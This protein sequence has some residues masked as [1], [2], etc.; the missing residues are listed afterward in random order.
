MSIPHTSL[1][2]SVLAVSNMF[3]LHTAGIVAFVQS[4]SKLFDVVKQ[5]VVALFYSRGI[6]GWLKR[7]IET[8]CLIVEWLHNIVLAEFVCPMI[9]FILDFATT[10]NNFLQELVSAISRIPGVPTQWAEDILRIIENIL[11]SVQDFLKDCSQKDFSCTDDM[12]GVP[13]PG[14]TRALPMPT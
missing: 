10:I 13:E 2:T 3:L 4:I 5:S 14:P 8:I 12:L 9:K 11:L 6:G 1:L 7:T